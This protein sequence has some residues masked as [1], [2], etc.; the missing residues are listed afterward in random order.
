MTSANTANFCYQVKNHK[1]V[2]QLLI[3]MLINFLFLLLLC[4]FTVCFHAVNKWSRLSISFIAYIINSGSCHH[5]M[6][7]HQPVL[8]YVHN[9]YT[10]NLANAPFQIFIAR[11]H[12]V[13]FVLQSQNIT[14]SQKTAQSVNHRNWTQLSKLSV[15]I[16]VK[17]GLLTE[18]N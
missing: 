6:K 10:G 18:R 12:Y 15:I 8:G 14:Q 3:F 5:I 16:S 7:E 17:T 4:Y 11:C 1:G 2:T 13:T 9:W